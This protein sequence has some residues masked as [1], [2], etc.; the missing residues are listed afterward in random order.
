MR[1][2]RWTVIAPAG[3]D[4]RNN[5]VYLC[6]C[7][8]GT[9]RLVIGFSLRS[10]RSRSCGCLHREMTAARNRERVRIRSPRTAPKGKGASE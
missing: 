7:D 8:C 2:G 10:G 6:R 4:R 3:R 5:D 9:Q 1:F